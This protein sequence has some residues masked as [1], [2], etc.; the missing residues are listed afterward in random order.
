MPETKVSIPLYACLCPQYG[1][2]ELISLVRV[3]DITPPKKG[4]MSTIYFHS[5]LIYILED[6]LI[7]VLPTYLMYIHS[8]SVYIHS[9]VVQLEEKM[10][11][12]VMMMVFHF[13]FCM[14]LKYNIKST[15]LLWD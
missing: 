9:I 8:I 2:D 4:V 11:G 14:T 6:R 1:N 5:F 3:P 12:A 10:C 7:I 15:G 13:V